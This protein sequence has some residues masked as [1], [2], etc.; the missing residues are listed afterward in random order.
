MRRS[1]G[2]QASGYRRRR[3]TTGRHELVALLLED[4][5][6]VGTL[7]LVHVEALAVVAAHA[8]AFHDLRAADGAPIAGLLADLAGVAFL[9]AFDPE[10]GQVG[11]DPKRRAYRTQVAAVQVSDEHGCG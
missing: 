6:P 3:R 4:D 11:Q 8:L 7:L 5:D 9:P 1:G 10:D 2:L